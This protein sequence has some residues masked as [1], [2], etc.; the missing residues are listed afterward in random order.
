MVSRNTAV[1]PSNKQQAGLQIIYT[2]VM[3]L[4]NQ[5]DDTITF[6]KYKYSI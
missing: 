1:P 3:F 4:E 2:D 6:Q 5:S